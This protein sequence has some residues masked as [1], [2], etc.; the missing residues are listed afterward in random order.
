M[1]ATCPLKR[2]LLLI[3]VAIL[4]LESSFLSALP[5]AEAPLSAS[6]S[7]A[8]QTADRSSAILI[9]TDRVIARDDGRL[10]VRG[11][12]ERHP[13]HL[14]LRRSGVKEVWKFSLRDGLLRVD[15]SG[16]STEYLRLRA[17]PQ[18]LELKPFALAEARDLS[19]ERIQGIQTEL[20][21]RVSRDQ[22]VRTD[23]ARQG[24]MAGVDTDNTAYLKQLVQEVGWIDVPRFGSQISV[25][26]FLLLQHSGDLGLKLAALPFIERDLKHSEGAQSYALF[27]D[28]LQLDLGRKQRYGTQFRPDAEGN[29]YVLPLEDPA[30]VD[31]FLNELGLPPLEKYLADASQLL[32][33]GKPIRIPRADE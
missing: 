23:P 9:E 3:V 22:A 13:D 14:L 18:D 10:V 32:F 29:P 26:A 15:R 6:L 8:W 33:K 5:Q 12:I 30:R 25:D 21:E 17:I 7:G 31:E 4:G 28:R 24:G 2:Y 20:R 1:N 27:Y 11:I 16:A 19:P